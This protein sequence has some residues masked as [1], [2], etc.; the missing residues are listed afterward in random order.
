MKQCE[1]ILNEIHQAV[2]QPLSR[3]THAALPEPK[4]LTTQLAACLRET[5]D[6]ETSR[7][8]KWL[9]EK[10]ETLRRLPPPEQT[11]CYRE[12]QTELGRFLAKGLP[13]KPTV[14]AAPPSVRYVKGVGERMAALLAKL[15][16]R[17]T[18]DLLVFFPH[19]YED[20][21]NLVPIAQLAQ[22]T[23]ATVHGV[24]RSVDLQTTPRKRF[25]ILHVLVE[26]RTGTVMVKWF[27][28]AYL[29]KV[30][31]PGQ[32]VILSGKIGRDP[33]SVSLEMENPEFEILGDTGEETIHT[34]RI[35]PIYHTTAGLTQRRIRNIMFHFIESTETV[36]EIFPEDL[37]VKYHL[38]G[39]AESLKNLHFPESHVPVEKLNNRRSRYHKRMIF[40]EFFLLEL[41]LALNQQGRR[42]RGRGI[43]FQ[44]NGD[45]ARTLMAGLP[46]PLTGSQKR[47]IGEIQRD[48]GRPVQM[49]RLLQGDV[50]CG[51]TV[52]A[53]MAAA[54]ALDNGY[55]VA[56][57]APTEILSE[58]LYFSFKGLFQALG[59]KT[60]LL[61]RSVKGREKETLREKIET[62]DIHAVVG[63][64]ALIQEEV[65][66]RKLGLVIIDEQHRFGVIQRATLIGKGV[67]P[68]LLV[69]TATPIPRSLSLTVYGDLDIS[70]IDEMPPGRSPVETHIVRA[71]NKPQLYRRIAAEVAKGRQAYIVYPLVEETEK[72]DLAAATEMSGHLAETV[73]PQHPVG[74]MHGR[75]SSEEKERVMGAFKKGE[76]KILVSTTVVEVGIDVPNATV[77]VIEHAERFGLAQLH[78]LRGRVGRGPHPSTCYLLLAGRMTEEAKRRISIMEE[79]TD[80]FRIAE[81]DLAIRGPGEFFGRKQSGLPDLVLANI[82]RDAPILE[83]AR[84]EAF[85]RIRQDPALSA[86]KHARLLAEIRRRFTGKFSLI[87]VG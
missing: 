23:T 38:P 87:R 86:P 63:T 76:I 54:I 6:P 79:T 43:S 66:F 13:A 7:M 28:Q 72:S 50:G 24:V 47:V 35:V 51:K 71:R 39:R 42:R 16:L 40:E 36:P 5:P 45:A 15:N 65:N 18:D 80:G 46:F 70:V 11:Q 14:R 20:R 32:E 48:M 67:S 1:S 56:V 75:M 64:Q 84:E 53:A 61:S 83:V 62:G 3:G 73:F 37:L 55:Q 74:L 78:Q 81:E 21:K 26:D 12:I 31:Q 27:N 17:T 4:R 9:Q 57:M 58:Q 69:M 22:D 41:V 2:S 60:A 68:D 33:Y 82:L 52:V 77:M 59:R 25:R 29:K 34:N 49:S 30:F 8:V 85:S 10:V 44:V 19:R